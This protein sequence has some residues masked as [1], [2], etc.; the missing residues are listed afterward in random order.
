M[1][2]KH[3]LCI[4]G[5][6]DGQRK[7]S[8]SEIM[9]APTMRDVGPLVFDPNP[10]FQE[11]VHDVYVYK[12]FDFRFSDG[13]EIKTASFWVDDKEKQ[14]FNAVMS[15]LVKCYEDKGRGRDE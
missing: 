2:N 7:V 10:S 9:K 12:H 8:P 4:G 3:G 13:G 1:S 11:L 6:L 15:A 5:P 14:P